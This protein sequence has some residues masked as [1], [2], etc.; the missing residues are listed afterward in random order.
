M[1][2]RA[3]IVDTG[4]DYFYKAKL[5]INKPAQEIFNFIANPENHSKFDGSG[6]VRGKI[7]GPKKLYLGAKFGMSMKQ[8]IPYP[9]KNEV[10][11]FQEGRSIAWQHILHNVWRYE[12]VAIDKNTTEVIESWDA[13]HARALWW[14]KKRKPWNWVPKAMGKS[15]VNLKRLLEND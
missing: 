7:A 2:L 1:S 11:E 6:M 4:I 13:T 9:I 14:I 15:L 12:L 8:G 5:I 3:E 10:V